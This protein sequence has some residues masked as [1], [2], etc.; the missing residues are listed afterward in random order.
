MKAHTATP[1]GVSQA[2][3][4]RICSKGNYICTCEGGLTLAQANAAYIVQAVNAYEPDQETIKVLTHA[5][6]DIYA[7]LKSHGY[8]TGLINAALSLAGE[9]D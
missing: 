9:P 4:H 7:F 3:E 5:M 6:K 2:W 1:W 8:N